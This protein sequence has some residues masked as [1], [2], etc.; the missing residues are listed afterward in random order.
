MRFC[1]WYDVSQAVSATLQSSLKLSL[2]RVRNV[3]G[4]AARI[5]AAELGAAAAVARVRARPLCCIRI[6]VSRPHARHKRCCMALCRCAVVNA[7]PMADLNGNRDQDLVS[8]QVGDSGQFGSRD[9]QVM[10]QL[11]GYSRP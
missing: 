2:R 1:L 10:Y 8:G 4:A 3:L 9:G 6:P 11:L 5:L 7:Y